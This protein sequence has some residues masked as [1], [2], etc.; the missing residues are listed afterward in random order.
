MTETQKVSSCV[1]CAT[2]L[3]GGGARCPACHDKCLVSHRA[4]GLLASWL[5]RLAWSV[6]TATVLAI[7]LFIVVVS[8]GI[9][10]VVAIS[11]GKG[12]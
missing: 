8:C 7:V 6:V 11:A 5:D 4:S 12:C 3:I 1:G 10:A 9:V 2:P